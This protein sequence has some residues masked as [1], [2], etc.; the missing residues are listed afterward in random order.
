VETKSKVEA[1][2]S[3]EVGADEEQSDLLLL[4]DLDMS[5]LGLD[6]DAY[7]D[8]IKLERKEYG[9]LSDDAYQAMRRKVK[10][11]ALFFTSFGTIL[12]K[13]LQI[14]QTFLL[15]PNIFSTAACQSRFEAQAR[16]NIEAEVQALGK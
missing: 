4:Q 12:N 1:L 3:G 2:L 14:L 8:L 6:A 13:Y 15:I 11:F 9:F 10:K 7:A 5:F 16:L